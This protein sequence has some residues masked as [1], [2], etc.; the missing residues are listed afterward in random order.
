MFKSFKHLQ[1][2]NF[3]LQ[4]SQSLWYL[5]RNSQL[6]SSRWNGNVVVWL[7]GLILWEAPNSLCGRIP[8]ESCLP[9]GTKIWKKTKQLWKPWIT[10][11]G[12]NISHLGKRKIIFKMPFLGDMLVPWRVYWIMNYIPSKFTPFPRSMICGLCWESDSFTITQSMLRPKQCLGPD[13]SHQQLGKQKVL[14]ATTTK[15]PTTARKAGKQMCN[16]GPWLEIFNTSQLVVFSWRTGW[17]ENQ[18]HFCICH[19]PFASTCPVKAFLNRN[20]KVTASS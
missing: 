8:S 3:F 10:L 9:Q 15:K 6:W 5:P 18:V 19:D 12:I 1:E 20:L 13:M 7:F 2:G 14:T 17:Y 4:K 11:Q 16:W